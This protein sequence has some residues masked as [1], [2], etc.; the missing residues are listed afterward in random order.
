[1]EPQHHSERDTCHVILF[2]RDG[3]EI[4]LNHS[5][6]GCSLLSVE[7]PRWERVPENLTAIVKRESQCD[8]VC[9][10]TPKSSP[11]D[12]ASS[13]DHYEVMESW[14]DRASVSQTVWKP[15]NSLSLNSFVNPQEFT[16]IEQCLR[17]LEGYECAPSSPFARRG[18]FSGLRDW[19]AQVIRPLGLYLSDSFRQYN[20]SPSST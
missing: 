4:L 11:K 5:D 9:L 8:A 16:R 20:A 15:I 19:T 1:M 18:W 17:E 6:A 3:T 13:I 10:F 2:G 12:R 14:R 7:I